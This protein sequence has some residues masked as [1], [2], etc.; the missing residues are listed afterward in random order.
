MSES[1]VLFLR[2]RS[3][4]VWLRTNCHGNEVAAVALRGEGSAQKPFGFVGVVKRRLPYFSAYVSLI[5]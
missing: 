3:V 5:L 2:I 4:R 1:H